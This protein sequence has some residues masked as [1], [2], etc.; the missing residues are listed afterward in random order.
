MSLYAPT[1]GTTSVLSHARRVGHMLVMASSHER[2]AAESHA[3][4]QMAGYELTGCFS[5]PKRD[6][7]WSKRS[8]RE[9]K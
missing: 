1:R 6:R 9:P 7:A 4:L 3:V 2:I 8:S 5:T